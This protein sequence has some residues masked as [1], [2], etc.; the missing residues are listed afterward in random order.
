MDI[1]KYGL[2]SKT[3]PHNPTVSVKGD[4]LQVVDKFTTL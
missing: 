4:E 1:Y 2:N 3:A